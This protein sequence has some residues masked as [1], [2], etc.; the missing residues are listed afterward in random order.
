MSKAYVTPTE[1]AEALQVSLQSLIASLGVKGDPM[2]WPEVAAALGALAK[3]PS[4]SPEDTQLQGVALRAA[5]ARVAKA[6]PEG[7]PLAAVAQT[8]GLSVRMPWESPSHVHLQNRPTG[9]PSALDL[10]VTASLPLGEPIPLTAEAE[11]PKTPAGWA[12]QLSAPVELSDKARR[13]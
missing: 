6:K 4:G 11:V 13:S 3:A 12:S 1:R 7:L 9:G 10:I 8:L 5:L 2:Q